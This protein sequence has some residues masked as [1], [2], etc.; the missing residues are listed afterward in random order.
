MAKRFEEY[1]N[2]KLPEGAKRDLAKI[3]NERY[4]SVGSVARQA[5]MELLKTEATE[6]KTAAA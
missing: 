5:I 4:Q 1:I 3:A 6:K 2:V